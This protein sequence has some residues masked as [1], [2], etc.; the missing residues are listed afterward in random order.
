M[1]RCNGAERVRTSSDDD[2]VKPPVEAA[3]E[4]TLLA[5][6]AV[7]AMLLDAS[8]LLA[9]RSER[10]HTCTTPSLSP[11]P[12][13]ITRTRERERVPVSLFDCGRVQY[14]WYLPGNRYYYVNEV[15]C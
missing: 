15:C 6:S 1:G 3:S 2:S 13:S 14:T 7:A 10:V 9:S 11:R 8:L 4:I 12:V 5:F